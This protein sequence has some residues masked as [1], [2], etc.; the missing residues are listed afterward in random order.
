MPP[1]DAWPLFVAAY[2][3]PPASHAR[4]VPQDQLHSGSLCQL[5]PTPHAATAAVRCC[6]PLPPT[7]C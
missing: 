2:T 3:S 4:S 1:L 7:W 5:A 6:T